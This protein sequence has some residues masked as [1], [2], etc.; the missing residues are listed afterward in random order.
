MKQFCRISYVS[1]AGVLLSFDKKNILIDG[2]CNS[3]VPIFKNPPVELKTQF[4]GGISPDKNID[5]ILFTHHHSDHFDPQTTVKFLKHNPNTVVITNNDAIREIRKQQSGLA[6]IQ[7]IQAG[8][9]MGLSENL[10]IIDGVKIQA[11]P[12][13]H[14]G[15]KYR[16]IQNFAYLIEADGK[17]ILHVGDAKPVGENY[18]DLNLTD[19]NLDLLIAPFPYV[20]LSAARR[21][22]K[23]YINPQKIAVVHFPYREL[24]SGG[25]IDATRKSFQRVEKDFIDTVFFEDIGDCIYI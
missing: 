9:P 4:I 5:I 7:L 10:H 12:L 3:V 18:A 2:F 11:I 6:N 13:L 20:G 15:D 22:I 21:I 19:K 14:D 1:N 23:K 16:D 24:D 17:R 8:A 25:W